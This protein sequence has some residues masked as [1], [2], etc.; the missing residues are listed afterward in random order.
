MLQPQEQSAFYPIDDVSSTASSGNSV[1]ASQPKKRTA[2]CSR[3]ADCRRGL[4]EKHFRLVYADRHVR[5]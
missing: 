1:L 3:G 4:L 5:E 2:L